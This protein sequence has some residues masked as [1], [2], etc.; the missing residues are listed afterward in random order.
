MQSLTRVISFFRRVLRRV[1]SLLLLR[2]SERHSGF[3]DGAR[4]L[5]KQ[6]Y[7]T[8]LHRTPQEWEVDTW[9]AH[10]DSGMPVAELWRS[11][12]DSEESRMLG[13]PL[14]SASETDFICEAYE[15]V[16]GAG[17]T[18]RDVAEIGQ[19]LAGRHITR[20][21]LLM[22]LFRRKSNEI[23][24]LGDVATERTQPAGVYVLGADRL[25]TLDEWNRRVTLARQPGSIVRKTHSRLPVL[26]GDDAVRV[27]VVASLYRGGRY[28]RKYLE[29]IT[30]QTIFDRCELIIIDA[31]SPE[32]EAAVI[33]EYAARFPQIVYERLPYRAPIYT[34]WNIGV[35][36]ARG[37]YITNAN[38]DDARR[39]D[40]LELQCGVL[41]NLPFVDVAYQ[42]VLYTIEEGLSIDEIERIGVTSRLPIITPHNLGDF[43]SPH[44][45]PMWRRSIHDD[46]GFFNEH[47][48]SAADWEFWIRCLIGGKNFYKINDPHVIYY[49]NPEGVSTDVSGPG[50]EEAR[51]VA[52]RY[53]RQL[54]PAASLEEFAEFERRC[55]VEP[56]ECDQTTDRYAFVQALLCATAA[57]SQGDRAG[58]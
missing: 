30:S 50:L 57:S 38:M 15:I 18:A 39:R 33:S 35:R 21:A 44:N 46:I 23:K 7:E 6:F 8:I 43:N 45:G 37:R 27:S 13:P 5:V 47:L 17:A 12:H 42:D 56:G 41:D 55:G 58:A 1:A 14:M 29:N 40:S 20:E 9:I 3:P 4:E 48:R 16:L 32:S 2:P 22:D 31:D 52:R 26:A 53:L 28:I 10:L 54:L 19:R 24:V 34:A 51:G 25:L 49:S 36:M 11:I